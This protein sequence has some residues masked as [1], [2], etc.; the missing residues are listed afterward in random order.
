M[1]RTIIEGETTYYVRD[2][3][4]TYVVGQTYPVNEVP[5]PH[6]R[7]ITNLIK[8]RMMNI[9][10]KLVAKQKRHRIKVAHITRY[11]PIRMISLCDSV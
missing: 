2:I 5:G 8:A 10:F 6:S 9:T 7:K 11:F 4:H 1:S 3:K